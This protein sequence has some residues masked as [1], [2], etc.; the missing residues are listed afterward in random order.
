VGRYR[1]PER[2]ATTPPELTLPCRLR[3]PLHP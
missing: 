1:T 2:A 3:A